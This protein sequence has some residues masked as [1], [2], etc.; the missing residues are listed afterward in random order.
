MLSYFWHHPALHPL[1]HI[2]RPSSITACR[3][4]LLAASETSQQL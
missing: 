3:W 1:W 4:R 2:I